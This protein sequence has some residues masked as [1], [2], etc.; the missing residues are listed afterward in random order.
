MRVQLAVDVCI[1][2]QAWMSTLV[3]DVR[4]ASG[5]LQWQS[6]AFNAASLH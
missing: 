1:G 3:F 5:T 4:I 6:C 2:M